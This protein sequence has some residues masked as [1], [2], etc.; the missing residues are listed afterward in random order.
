[1]EKTAW[2]YVKKNICSD[3]IA[4]FEELAFIEIPDNLRD[5][6][7][8]HNNGRPT[9]NSFNTKR[10]NGR[11]FD[12]LLS[13]NKDDKE[14]VFSIYSILSNVLPTNLVAIAADPFGNF[15]C[16][17]KGNDLKVVFWQHETSTS[18]DT[19]KVFI[20]FIESLN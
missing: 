10:S 1:M 8:E 16:L 17:D 14:N 4:E 20:A 9:K 13:F 19:E 15:I 2:K 18:E 11:V 3:D 6:I 12:K 5:F 7:L